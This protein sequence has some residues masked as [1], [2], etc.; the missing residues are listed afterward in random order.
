MNAVTPLSPAPLDMMWFLPTGGDGRYLGSAEGSRSIDHAY[1]RQSAQAVDRLGYGGILLPTGRACEDALVTAASL[2]SSTER[3]RFLVALR[4]GLTLPGEAARQYAT[5]DRIAR[6]RTMI[7]LVCGGNPADLA[8]ERDP[9]VPRAI[10]SL[11]VPQGLSSV[12]ATA[13]ST[14]RS[15]ASRRGANGANG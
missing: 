15:T 11:A 13:P 2:L 14:A 10:P 7:N 4:P 8:G 3:L 6:G 1:L 9:A 5:L 12:A